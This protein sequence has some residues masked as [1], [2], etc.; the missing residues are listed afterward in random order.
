VSASHI[1]VGPSTCSSR[2]LA[3]VSPY[4][5]TMVIPARRSAGSMAERAASAFGERAHSDRVSSAVRR[6]VLKERTAPGIRR[7]AVAGAGFIHPMFGRPASTHPYAE[8]EQL[9]DVDDERAINGDTSIQ[10][11]PRSAEPVLPAVRPRDAGG[12][13]PWRYRVRTHTP[14]GQVGRAG[15]GYSHDIAQGV[16]GEFRRKR[17][18]NTS[19]AAAPNEADQVTEQEWRATGRSQRGIQLGDDESPANRAA[20]AGHLG[21]V[22]PATGN[23]GA[24][25]AGSGNAVS[26][27][28]RCCDLLVDSPVSQ[29]GYSSANPAGCRPRSV[30]KGRCV[31]HAA[32][33]AT[34]PCTPMREREQTT[35]PPQAAVAVSS[36]GTLHGRTDR[37]DSPP[38]LALGPRGG[39][40]RSWSGSDPQIHQGQCSDLPNT[41]HGVQSS[42]QVQTGCQGCKSPI[43]HTSGYLAVQYC[44]Q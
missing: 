5:E 20:R 18:R 1:G 29:R 41:R 11:R 3:P 4:T 7:S 36:S 2:A 42:S 28:G 14:C 37:D 13:H 23:P 30:I 34:R 27:P 9:T 21:Q 40:L 31:E 33:C 35:R 32:P 26:L 10:D 6:W 44:S 19:G 43:S 38:R 24:C 17:R 8:L 15:R 25:R 16:C 12:E 22:M 39:L